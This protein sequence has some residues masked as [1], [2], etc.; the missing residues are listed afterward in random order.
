MTKRSKLG[1]VCDVTCAECAAPLRRRLIN[2]NTLQSIK[3]FFCGFDCKA[4]WQRR[5]RP[6][7]REWL[8]QKYIVEKLDCGAIAKLVK[9]N[10]KR[11]W[12][13][14]RDDGIPTRPR[15]ALT[16]KSGFIKGEPSRFL[17]HKQKSGPD[18]P[19]W[20]GGITPQRQALYASDEWRMAVKIVYARDR[21]SCRRCGVPQKISA[22]MGMKMHVHHIV[23]FRVKELRTVVSNLILLC[24]SCHLFVHSKRNVNH[25][26]RK[27]AS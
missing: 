14:L 1:P 27:V 8:E 5:A 25:D 11:I 21:K 20:Q 17:G 3:Q 19:H 2:P 16:S 24:K 26:F 22:L 10:S 4:A 12:E 9:R 6:V 18:S 7:T 15:G 13:W 23:G